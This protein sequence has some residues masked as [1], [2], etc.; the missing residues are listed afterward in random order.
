MPEI[1]WTYGYFRGG[2]RHLRHAL[3]AISPKRLGLISHDVGFRV[4][5]DRTGMSR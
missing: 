5:T 4:L 3:L 1:K 2:R